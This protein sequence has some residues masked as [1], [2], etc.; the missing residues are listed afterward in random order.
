[1]LKNGG[2]AP[3]RANM[4]QMPTIEFLHLG[5]GCVESIQYDADTVDKMINASVAKVTEL[6]NWYSA[7]GA[8]YKYMPTGD[9]KYQE[10]DDFARAD[11]RD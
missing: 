4:S 7:G 10:Y 11:E 6:F 8:P 2:F 5:T 9:V 3:Y 1:M